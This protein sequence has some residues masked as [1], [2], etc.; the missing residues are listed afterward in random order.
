MYPYQFSQ[1]LMFFYLYCFAG[2]VIESTIVSVSRR[3]LVNRG[4]LRGPYLPLYGTGALAIL[5]IALP[6]QKNPAAVYFGGML[7]ATVLEYF[8]GWAM[9]SIF[10][11][12]YWDYSKNKWNLHGRICLKSSLFWGVLAVAL[13]EWIHPPV[14][15]FVLGMD[16]TLLLVLDVLIFCL[17]AVDTVAAV[18]TTLDLNKLLAKLTQVKAEADRL[19]AE[20][21]Q[22]RERDAAVQREKIERLRKELN[23][24]AER[25][26]FW[27]NQLIQAHP[28]ARSRNFDEAL[29]LLR[30]KANQRRKKQK[31]GKHEK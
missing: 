17:M 13:V 25:A 19:R 31:D 3:R 14:E 7:G 30:S 27:K 18:R 4:F 15:R 2:W 28:S 5:L 12:K 24:L 10:K 16:H 21:A 26:G 8:T 20:M 11:M 6:L 22:R 9:E 29:G 1:W 23:S